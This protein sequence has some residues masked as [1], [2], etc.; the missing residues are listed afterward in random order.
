M[1][2]I[3]LLQVAVFVVFAALILQVAA[4][5]F[6]KGFME[7]IGDDVENKINP[8]ITTSLIPSAVIDA[9]LI[10][11]ST[12]EKMQLNNNYRLENISINADIRVND[13]SVKTTWWLIAFQ[14]IIDVVIFILLVRLS[15]VIYIIIFNIYINAI[16][17]KRSVNLIRQTGF[18]LIIYSVAD[19]LSQQET[20]LKSKSLV[21][22]PV[23][24]I[25]TSDFNFVLLLCGLLVLILA[26]AF[27][28]GAKLKE[29]QEFT[30]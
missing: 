1:K 30:I 23:T 14:V 16:F 19:Y 2:K 27:K 8:E 20:Y 17:N 12:D 11:S 6:Y 4:I 21:N 18:L 5:D 24:I 3:R 25:N 28:Q 26:E 22:L 13:K 10:N 9:R 15:Y 7:G 29:E